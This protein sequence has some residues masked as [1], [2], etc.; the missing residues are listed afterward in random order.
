[1]LS[2]ESFMHMEQL[3]QDSS[4]IPHDCNRSEDSEEGLGGGREALE[5]AG[6][7]GRGRR[8]HDCNTTMDLLQHQHLLLAQPQLTSSC[9]KYFT[10][11]H[12]Q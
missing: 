3:L 8:E 9:C 4:C 11:N 12:N 6:G 10:V 5:Q 1:M 2:F 7:D